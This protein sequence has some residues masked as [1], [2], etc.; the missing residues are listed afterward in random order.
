MVILRQEIKFSWLD[1][2]FSFS[3]SSFLLLFVT[4]LLATSLLAF[5]LRDPPPV[6]TPL[7][8]I[9]LLQI[10]YSL[11]ITWLILRQEIKFSWLNR[12]FSFSSFFIDR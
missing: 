7:L 2:G 10:R 11:L 12:G 9:P 8:T 4:L 1:R 6:V 3:F 5:T